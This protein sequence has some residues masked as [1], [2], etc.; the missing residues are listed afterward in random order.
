MFTP[1]FAILLMQAPSAVPTLQP[2]AVV[3]VAA[4]QVA[5]A[6]IE[7]RVQIAD[8]D[9]L[10]IEESSAA[11]AVRVPWSAVTALQVRHRRDGTSMG[12][13]AGGIVG[14]LVTIGVLQRALR[15]DSG[16]QPIRAVKGELKGVLWGTVGASA[17][18]LLGA[19]IGSRFHSDRW[20]AVRLG[21][22]PVVM[23][24]RRVGFGVDV[25]IAF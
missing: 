15:H 3:R 17:G 5:A 25:R 21:I 2:G 6:P 11:A 14:G 10:W 12:F 23:D 16:S 1:L 8:G 7:G 20:E 9:A 22:A 18:G 4:P 13:V 19:A 24:P